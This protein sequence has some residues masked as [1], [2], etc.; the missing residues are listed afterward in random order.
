MLICA[1]TLRQMFV[2]SVSSR[3]MVQKLAKYYVDKGKWIP[4]RLLVPGKA[5]WQGDT[6]VSPTYIGS[7]YT[8]KK[9]PPNGHVQMTVP[10]TSGFED[11]RRVYFAAVGREDDGKI[12][13]LAP[14]W[15]QRACTGVH[16]A[17]G[18]PVQRPHH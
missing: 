17:P 4:I 10:K 14:R 2:L 8:F 7:H 16:I 12:V 15:C 11:C 9:K 3:A 6:F 18:G 13:A 1:A 5:V